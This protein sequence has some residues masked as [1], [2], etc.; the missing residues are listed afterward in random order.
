MQFIFD[1]GNLVVIIVGGIR[2]AAT[3]PSGLPA[4]AREGLFEHGLLECYL[5]MSAR[6]LFAMNLEW[7]ELKAAYLY[8]TAFF[9]PCKASLNVFYPLEKPLVQYGFPDFFIFKY[10]VY[11]LGSASGLQWSD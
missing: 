8:K 2:P 5:A 11:G 10:R 7:L 1:R 6:V 3:A 9:P 4:L